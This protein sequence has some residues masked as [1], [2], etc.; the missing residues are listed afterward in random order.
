MLRT[1]QVVT[2]T[3]IK[4]H[5]DLMQLTPGQ[6][7]RVNDQQAVMLE[8]LGRAIDPCAGCWAEMNGGLC[9]REIRIEQARPEL[10]PYLNEQ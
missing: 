10:C 4:A 3:K 1:L 7:I 2:S 6:L 8:K 5:G 9:C